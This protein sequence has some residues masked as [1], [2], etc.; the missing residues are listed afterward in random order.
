ML[1]RLLHRI[2]LWKRHGTMSGQLLG[3]QVVSQQQWAG[4]HH[5]DFLAMMLK[6]MPAT[7][8]PTPLNYCRVHR[9]E[10]SCRIMNT[11]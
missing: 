1:R 10:A 4:R 6:V 8:S 2:M 7:T 3:T 5:S 11:I 9:V